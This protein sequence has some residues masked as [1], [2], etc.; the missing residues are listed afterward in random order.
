[1]PVELHMLP[2]KAGDA[3]LLIDRSEG[4][5]YS[6]LIDAGLAVHEVVAYLQSIGIYHLD[7]IILSHPDLDHLQGLLSLLENPLIS[8]DQM[9]CF[10]LS[11]L[12][13][14]VRTGKMPQP[15]KGTH[16][17][18][19]FECLR[20]TLDGMDKILKTLAGKNVLTLQVSAGHRLNLGSLHIEVLYPWDGFY[21]T[22]H[23]TSMIKKL[24]SKKRWPEDWMQDVQVVFA[25]LLKDDKHET[26]NR[27]RYG[28]ENS[29]DAPG[30]E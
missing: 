23:S 9:W 21:D 3:T 14:F 30:T 29:W 6:V 5:P 27:W 22:L 20:K 28:S 2:I 17:V 8:I 24:L 18:V 1:M 16:E 7:L 15:K 12:K 13:E 19:Y 25:G 11:F 10:D 26:G 4:R